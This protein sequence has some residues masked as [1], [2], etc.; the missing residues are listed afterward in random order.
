MKSKKFILAQ[1]KEI[2]DAKG[3][4]AT[5]SSPPSVKKQSTNC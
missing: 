1:I 4:T 5:H 3:R 2:V